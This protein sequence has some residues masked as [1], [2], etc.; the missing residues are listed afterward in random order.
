MQTPQ[1]ARRAASCSHAF[2]DLPH[3]A[4]A[5]DRRHAADRTR[6][7]RG[8]ARPRRRAQPEDHHPHSTSNAALRLLGRKPIIWHHKHRFPSYEEI[9]E[10]ILRAKHEDMRDDDVTSRLLIP[11]RL[12]GSGPRSCRSKPASSAA[13]PSSH[14]LPAS[15]TSASRSKA[16]GRPSSSW[17]AATPPPPRHLPIRQNHRADAIAALGRARA[18]LT[19]SSVSP[20]SPPRS[21]SYVQAIPG[22]AASIYDTRKTTPGSRLLEKYAVTCGGGENHRI[23]LYDG[24][25]VKDNHI[26][27]IPLAQL[28]RRTVPRSSPSAATKPRTASSRSR[29]T[30]LEQFR[31]VFKVDRID[32]ILLDNMNCATMVPGRADLRH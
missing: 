11:S 24:L 15:T 12:N 14:D 18:C 6:R 1:I 10:L 3:P 7:R 19:S 4:R 9:A 13:C 32:S 20:A 17:K 2:G 5:G 30:R 27:A 21:A 22:T 29:W 23:G 25:L 8:L 31:E 16:Y 28:G 26:A